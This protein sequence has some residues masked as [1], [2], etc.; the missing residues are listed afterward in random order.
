[1]DPVVTSAVVSGGLDLIGGLF[2][3]SSAREAYR[4]RYQDSVQDLRAAGLNPALAYGQNPGGGAQTADFGNIGNRTAS[5]AQAAAAADKTRAEANLLKA[6]RTDL[7]N[8]V[9]IRNNLLN[10]QA[11]AA[12]SSADANT[13]RAALLNLEYGIGR[14]TRDTDIAARK[15]YNRAIMLGIPEAEARARY[16]KQTGVASFYLNNATDIAKSVAQLRAAQGLNKPRVNIY[17][18]RYP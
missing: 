8:Q 16:F 6:Q 17:N 18:R 10:R 5:A 9:Q 3:Q 1:M 2:S 13:A 15:A 12:G 11:E 4:H 7:I 14:E